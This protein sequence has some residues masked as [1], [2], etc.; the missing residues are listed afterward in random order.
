[1]YINRKAIERYGTYSHFNL[2]IFFLLITRQ[3]IYIYKFYFKVPTPRGRE[4]QH[5]ELRQ[6]AT[7]FKLAES[8]GPPDTPQISRK[9]QHQHQQ[10]VHSVTPM[11]QPHHQGP[12]QHTS[13]QQQPQQQLSTQQHTSQQHQTVQE[14]SV[15]S[16]P[17][18][19]P[20][21]RSTSPQQQQQ[22]QQQ[23]QP[24]PQQQQQQPQQQPQQQQQQ[25]QPPPPQPPQTN[26]PTVQ[27]ASSEPAID[28]IT[29][30][31]KKSTLNPN[32]KE[33]NPNAKPFTPVSN[34]YY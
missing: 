10:D 21:V 5:S 28:K 15:T 33:F 14:E 4:E 13:P 19:G 7:E 9:Q 22:Q 30:A 1:M 26:T 11:N 17:P 16:K 8:Q 2:Y 34:I 27:Q 3:L 29:T 18:S 24:Q 31:F 23:P 12:H 25:Q 32:A 20:L 6:F